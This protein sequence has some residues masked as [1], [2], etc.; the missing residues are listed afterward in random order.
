MS[1]KVVKDAT[2]YEAWE[3]ALDEI[4]YPRL[5]AEQVVDKAKVVFHKDF[6]SLRLTQ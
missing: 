6:C 1:T 2:K 3:G 5:T 4:K